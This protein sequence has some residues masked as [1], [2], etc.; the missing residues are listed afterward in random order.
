[1]SDTATLDL[2][3]EQL[4]ELE[5]DA[6]LIRGRIEQ[7][8][9]LIA[10]VERR[11]GGRP[12]KG[13]IAIADSA[14][15]TE[16]AAAPTGR[17]IAAPHEHHRRGSVI[18]TELANHADRVLGWAARNEPPD[19]QALALFAQCLLDLSQQARQLERLPVDDDLVFHGGEIEDS[20]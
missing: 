2:L 20:L 16:Q 5:L 14:C 1:M 10:Q 4:R 19:A 18:S 11:R 15:A 17:R 8:A 12:R 3:R 13:K 9:T 7:C 6:V